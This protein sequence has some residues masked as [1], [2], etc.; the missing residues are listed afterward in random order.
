MSAFLCFLCNKLLVN[1]V[2]FTLTTSDNLYCSFIF[3]G[4]GMLIRSCK[5]LH[6]LVDE[7]KHK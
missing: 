2:V 7:L 3:E 6:L 1:C 5:H 4:G